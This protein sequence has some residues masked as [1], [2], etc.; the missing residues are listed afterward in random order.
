MK[1]NYEKP[2]A[3]VICFQV[4]EKL[5]VDGKPGVETSGYDDLYSFKDFGT[6]ISG[7]QLHP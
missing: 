2:L 3:T 7:Y 4:N 5:A 1:K 6:A